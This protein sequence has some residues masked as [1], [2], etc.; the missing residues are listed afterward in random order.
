LVHFMVLPVLLLLL[1]MP[2]SV[3]WEEMKLFGN[4]DVLEC[5]RRWSWGQR[6]R[7]CCWASLDTYSPIRTTT[8]LGKTSRVNEL[9]R[10]SF[11]Y[12][13]SASLVLDRFS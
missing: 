13:K 8:K 9:P 4:R 2:R 7:R 1:H 3:K 6:S 11:A 10:S 5:R 12:S